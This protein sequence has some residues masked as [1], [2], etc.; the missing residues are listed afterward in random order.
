MLIAKAPL[1]IGLFG[2]GCDFESF[3]REHTAYWINA[4]IDKFVWCILHPRTDG[5]IYVGYSKQEIV[6]DWRQVEHKLVRE[7][8]GFYEGEGFDTRGLELKFMSDIPY[9]RGSGL[10]SSSSFV[11]ALCCALNAHFNRPQDHGALSLAACEIE[12]HRAK[13]PIG[14][15]DQLAATLGGLRW[16]E[17]WGGLMNPMELNDCVNFVEQHF[18]L[19]DLGIE[20]AENPL[21]EQDARNKSGENTQLLIELSAIAKEAA[22]CLHA[23]DVPNLIGCMNRHWLAKKKLSSGV[24]NERIDAICE[25]VRRQGGACKVSGAGG[26][27]YLLTLSEKPLSLDLKQE[28]WRV[29]RHGGRVV[30][31]Q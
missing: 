26:G 8:L 9:S 16:Y 21:P 30:Y 6:D 29:C 15:Q 11:V 12:I 7:T 25:E 13:S 28:S 27:G 10:G 14:V 18:R 4:A 2:G 5:K 22:N 1:R 24:T 19:Y 17:A 23:K 31:A 20:R 3:Y